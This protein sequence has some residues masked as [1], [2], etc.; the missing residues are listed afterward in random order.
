MATVEEL[1]ARHREFSS[2]T[3]RLDAEVLLS[4]VLGKPRSYLY[5]WPDKTLEPAQ[6]HDFESMF[7]RRA[8][9]EPVA[10]IIGQREFWSLP[11]MVNNATL[12][13]RPETELL[14]EQA[15]K[16]GESLEKEKGES[17]SLLDLGTGT[18]AIALAIASEKPDW[19]I[20][21][22]DKHPEAV[23]LA[24]RNQAILG[25]GNVTV[26]Q[27]DWFG[28]VEG[29]FHLIVSNPPYIAV[30]DPHLQQGDLIHEPRSAL[31]AAEN[32]LADI[33]QIANRARDYLLPQGW[34]AL[35][36]GEQQGA[37]CEAMFAQAGFSAI[38]VHKDLSGKDRVIYGRG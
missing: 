25:L 36:H 12:I 11:F 34:L 15:L 19:Q 6:V 10:H 22:T 23:A 30:G 14:V 38:T 2:G 27:S 5:T 8:A 35:E 4:H 24:K 7:C 33:R 18:G 3:T 20:T 16:L 37:A 26:Q 28:S 21:A 32:G 17:I 13:P 29:R 9:G 31:V 1:L